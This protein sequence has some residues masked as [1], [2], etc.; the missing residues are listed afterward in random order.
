M[1]R[2][3][4]EGSG[5]AH[6]GYTPER[7]PDLDK[8][9]R[10][11]LKKEIRNYTDVNPEEIISKIEA[12]AHENI[13]NVKEH[14]ASTLQPILQDRTQLFVNRLFGYQKRMCRDNGHCR[15][16]GC[17]F[18]HSPVGLPMMEIDERPALSARE[19]RFMGANKGAIEKQRRLIDI[20][21]RRTDLPSDVHSVIEQLRRLIYRGRPMPAQ[22]Q[23]TS[24]RF[25]I[26]N[27][28]DWMTTE[29]LHTYPG[30]VNVTENGI[31]ECATRQD[32][33]RVFNMIYKID[34]N[35]HPTWIE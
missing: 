21:S 9:L 19:E 34:K 35:S 28:Q 6:T 8:N 27:R 29:H 31:I 18:K 7:I 5:S 25:I 13:P 15:R 20:L 32:A 17:Y 14:L 4:A 1:D 23:D 22:Q 30:V 33:E 11:Y 3:Y 26:N 24:T 10:I 16:P 2:N 12:V